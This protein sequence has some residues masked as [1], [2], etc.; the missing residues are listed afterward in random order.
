MSR[1]GRRPVVLLHGCGGSFESA[2]ETTGW[3]EALRAAGRTPVKI[4]LPGHGVIPAPHD[5]AYYADLAGLV[6]K[7]LPA[8]P[9]DAIGFSLGAKI[10]L[11]I[12]LRAPT[13]VGRMVLGGVG[14]NVFA[15]E[16]IAE[17]AALALEHGP[18][19]DT[20]PPVLAFLKTWEP[21][22]N[23]PLAVAAVL[24]RPP[25]PVFTPERLEGIV[26]PLLVVNGTADPVAREASRLFASLPQAHQ[27]ALGG[28][29]H[30]DLTAQAAFIAE[31]MR[32][33]ERADS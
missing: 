31:S 15:P 19:A 6:M 14:D 11:E 22:R 4:H 16:R 26:Q 18:T 32:F 13:N 17:A 29:G 10:L 30:F 9:F 3:L 5:P 28:V 33:L 23:D 25:N 2:F 1:L 21:D 27:I 12:A 20:P 24:R 7:E 8:E